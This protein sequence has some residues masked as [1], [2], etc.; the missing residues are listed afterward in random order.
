M[1]FWTQDFQKGK[2][3]KEYNL[4]YY[5]EI[6]QVMNKYKNYSVLGHLD[7]IKR[8]DLEGVYPYKETKDILEKILK[9]AIKDG[10]GI[11]INTSNERYGLSDFTSCKDIL[12]LYKQLG[13]RNYYVWK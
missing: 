1:E 13:G 2:T 11:E 8:D 6:Y 4:A 3:Q 7:A 12:L 10:K 5:E 9:L